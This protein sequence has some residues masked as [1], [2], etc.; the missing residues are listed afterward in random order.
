V[1]SALRAPGLVVGLGRESRAPTWAA[2]WS[3]NRR[4]S[5][6]IGR[7]RVDPRRSKS[8]LDSLRRTLAHSLLSLPR[9]NESQGERIGESDGAAVGP[10]AG[11]CDHRWVD[12]SPSSGSSAGSFIVC[13]P[14]TAS[15]RASTIAP[16]RTTATSHSRWWRHPL[17][18][19]C[20]VKQRRPWRVPS[21]Q[22]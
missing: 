22:P 3:V 5:I 17:L 12:A 6:P 11:V 8:A 20:P 7:L 16:S 10:L 13:E 2:A 4:P 15:L 21:P 1:H 19:Q 9:R 18:A 14:T